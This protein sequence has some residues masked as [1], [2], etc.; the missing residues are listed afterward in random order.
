MEKLPARDEYER[1]HDGD[2]AAGDVGP[3]VARAQGV[4]YGRHRGEEQES[5]A[6]DGDE[7]G[8]QAFFC[9]GVGDELEDAD[10]QVDDTGEH[11]EVGDARTLLQQGDADGH[12]GHPLR[13]VEQ[14][15]EVGDPLL[16]LVLEGGAED[17][18]GAGGEEKDHQKWVLLEM[19]GL[20]DSLHD[21]GQ[22]HAEMGDLFGHDLP[23]A[24]S[25]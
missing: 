12:Q 4:Q 8:C 15:G 24:G 17:D 10:G 22:A 23:S 25:G 6:H 14:L 20:I 9:F 18:K 7:T 11:E 1:A 3:G 21:Q 13:D 2:H 5:G 16:D 19:L